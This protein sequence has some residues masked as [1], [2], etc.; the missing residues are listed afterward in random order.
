VNGHAAAVAAAPQPPFTTHRLGSGDLTEFVNVYPGQSIPAFIIGQ[1]IR[2]PVKVHDSGRATIVGREWGPNRRGGGQAWL[3][4][5]KFPE[6][7]SWW[8][9]TEGEVE[10]W[11]Q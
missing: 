4:Y 7:G 11:Q 9:A 1:P 3:Y 10:K 8:E 6:G 5:V 2:V